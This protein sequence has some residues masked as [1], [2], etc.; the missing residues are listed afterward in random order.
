[1]QTGSEIGDFLAWSLSTALADDHMSI[2]SLVPAADST[3]L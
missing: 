1:M 2:F 3:R